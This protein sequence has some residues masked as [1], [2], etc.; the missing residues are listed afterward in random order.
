MDENI[1]W[2]RRD[3]RTYDSA[4]L[5]A[6]AKDGAKVL[7]VFIF[8]TGVLERFTNP[9]DRRLS[10]IA[11]SLV[12]MNKQMGGNLLVLHGSAR[13]IIPKLAEE[14]GADGVYAA[15]DY[16]PSTIARDKAVKEKTN[17]Q[18]VKDH[19]IFSGGEVLKGDDT[20]FKV[21]TPYSKAWRAKL[22]PTDIFEYDCSK[23]NFINA[24]VQQFDVT[25]VDNPQNMLAKIGYEFVDIDEWKPE[26][27]QDILKE[28]IKEKSQV[29]KDQRDFLAVDGTSKISPYLRFGN[30]SV[31]HAFRLAFEA[32]EK[33]SIKSGEYKN[34]DHF[35]SEL[36]WREFNIMIL[37]NF[38]EIPELEFIEKYRG[39]I[40]W[41]QDAEK[42]QAWK[43]GKTGFPVVDAAMRQLTQTGWMHNRARMIVA[44]FLTK[45]LH[46][47]W[48]LGE[49]HFAQYLMDYEQAS[50]VGGWQW[51][52]STG[53]D[54]Q[55]Y[56][57]IF[58]PFLQSKRFDSQG[59]YIRAFV[60]ELAHL[61]ASKIHEPWDYVDEADYPRPIVEHAKAKDKAI[62]M[63][64]ALK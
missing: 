31:R 39:Q 44:S 64:K 40:P 12:H 45:D 55:P 25:P 57:R 1:W 33:V 14:I 30:I 11:R 47:D 5:C 16:E 63:F 46:L 15:R 59:D 18:L 27:A 21:Y 32:R 34:I 50:N 62:A 2:I 24:A 19:V 29:Y 35:I 49:E 3:F 13:E 51:S 58:N 37:A 43:D 23:A 6:A 20:P 17:L 28:F 4:A 52:A 38:P 26:Y 41:E 10:F 36:I 7:P 42:L 56:F 9:K 53:T 61:D 54:A 22:Q 8:D 60:P 48:R